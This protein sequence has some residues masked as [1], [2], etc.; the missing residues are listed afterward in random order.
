MYNLGLLD[1]ESSLQDEVLSN[2]KT[3]T[4][5]VFD[6]YEMD[7]FAGVETMND[8]SQRQVTALLVKV[9][10]QS[11]ENCVD[12]NLLPQVSSHKFTVALSS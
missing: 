7:L 10:V 8:L 12:R 9:Y 2:F 4:K 1:H 6:R 3:A 11:L 5:A